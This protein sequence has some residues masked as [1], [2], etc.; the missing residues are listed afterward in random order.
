MNVSDHQDESVIHSEVMQ[1]VT[2]IEDERILYRRMNGN[3]VLIQSKHPLTG[4]DLIQRTS[5]FFAK[6]GDEREISI[7]CHPS[8]KTKSKRRTLPK[9]KW[10]DY[11]KQQ[12]EQFG[13]SVGEDMTA[14]PYR[15]VNVGKH[16]YVFQSVLYRGS[17]KITDAEKFKEMISKGIGPN[18]A[19]GCGLPLVYFKTA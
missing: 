8:C 6:N 5:L 4:N 11:L 14:M 15:K 7:V 10:I 3:T 13:F 9:N 12:G 18:K 17:V 16:D 19:F 1:R 2:N